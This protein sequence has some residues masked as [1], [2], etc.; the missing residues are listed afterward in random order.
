MEDESTM[1]TRIAMSNLILTEFAMPIGTPSLAESAK[2]VST[3]S[4]T[5]VVHFP[6]AKGQDVVV[7]SG[8]YLREVAEKSGLKL[9]PVL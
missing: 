4:L 3:V 2:A 8:Q 7:D 1:R 6:Y 5:Q 9:T